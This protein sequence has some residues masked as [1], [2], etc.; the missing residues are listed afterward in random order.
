MTSSGRGSPTWRSSARWPRRTCCTLERRAGVQG[1]ARRLDR[2]APRL[3]DRTQRTPGGAGCAG[4]RMRCVRCASVGGGAASP[5]RGAALPR[6]G[7]GVR[8]GAAVSSDCGRRSARAHGLGRLRASWRGTVNV[9]GRGGPGSGSP[10]ALPGRGRAARSAARDI[11]LVR[12]HAW[13]G[14]RQGGPAEVA[15]HARPSDRIRT[16]A[17]DGRGWVLKIGRG[18]HARCAGAA[19]EGLPSRARTSCGRRCRC[20]PGCSLPEGR[21]AAY[22]VSSSAPFLWINGT[23]EQPNTQGALNQV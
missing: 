19:C 14:L 15:H 2:G 9:P 21:L 10:R 17:V 18:E 5:L 11:D 13:C 6:R 1:R 16:S 4:F 3:Q 7:A 22:T 8:K 23:S 20:P 12:D